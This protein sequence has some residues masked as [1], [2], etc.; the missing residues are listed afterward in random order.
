MRLDQ[1]SSSKKA[2]LWLLQFCLVSVLLIVDLVN[3]P[4]KLD[5][6]LTRIFDQA[7]PST[8]LIVQQEI[9][10]KATSQQLILVGADSIEQAIIA[11]DDL[12]FQLM[13]LSAIDYAQSKFDNLPSLKNIVDDN[14]LYKHALLSEKMRELLKTGSADAVFSYQ[15]SL[16]NQVANQA[17]AITLEADPSLS[18][19]DFISRPMAANAG[20]SLQQD[21]LLTEFKG[22]HYVFV[23]FKSADTGINIDSA[24]QLTAEIEQLTQADGV[25]Y[26][27]AGTIFYSSQASQQGQ[28]EMLLYGSLSIICT[29]ILILL[30]YRNSISLIATASLLL[31]SFTYGYLGLSFFYNQV[32]IIALVFSVTLIGIAADYSFHA[33]TELRFSHFN[34]LTKAQPLSKIYISL[35]MSFI[36]TGAGYALLLL[37]PFTLFKQIALFTLFGLFGALLCVLLLYP[38]LLPL[39]Q[40]QLSAKIS[41]NALH[42][43]KLIDRVNQCQKAI[44]DLIQNYKFI[45]IAILTLSIALLSQLS[46]NDDIRN[47]YSAD[48]SLQSQEIKI[49]Q[50][51][52]SK[53]DLQYFLIEQGDPQALLETEEKLTK[54]LKPLLKNKQLSHI[55]AISQWLPSIQ[56]QKQNHQ[57]VYQ[58]YTQGKFNPLQQLLPQFA[59]DWIDHPNDINTASLLYPET[60]LQSH[61][62]KLH[63]QQWLKHSESYYSIVKLSGI[64]NTQ[65]LESIAQDIPGVLLVDKAESIS[66][67]LSQFRVQLVIVLIAAILAAA[68]V[69]SGR[70]GLKTGLVGLTVPIFAL[71]SSLLISALFQPQLNIFNLVASIL[72][73]ALGLDY[74]V[75]YAEHGFEKKITLTTTMSALS[76]IFVFAI[77]IFSTMPAIQSFGLT[78]FIGVLLTF[79][80]APIVTLTKPSKRGKLAATQLK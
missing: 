22:K 68:L 44:V 77:L 27:R 59:T 28:F 40:K 45:A 24:Q 19:A 9:E 46:F 79:I 7:Q 15:F 75:F 10:R 64:K 57:I 48:K 36:T 65:E 34:Q 47:F 33:L 2:L 74:S 29:L 30:I 1:I 60:W 52:K 39:I 71:V 35:V 26:L 56:Q 12:S 17:V 62:G 21:H 51:L 53:W 72:I 32:S 41:A 37:A 73:L 55:S 43:P 8:S 20:L 54:Q 25:E 13:Q 16:L 78:V 76:S 69:F 63:Q 5:A 61:L 4:L 11:A 23:T 50:I 70:Y 42:T 31:I 6:N 66:Q 38:I 3:T 58:A 67:Q 18:L 14:V 80:L 49:K